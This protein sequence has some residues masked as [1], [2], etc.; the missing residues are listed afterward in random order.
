MRITIEKLYKQYKNTN[1]DVYDRCSNNRLLHL[2]PHKFHA[3]LI[4]KELE[5]LLASS[6]PFDPRPILR[7]LLDS[8]AFV[9]AFAFGNVDIT[10]LEKLV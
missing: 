6:E 2:I 8:T 3:S 7:K 1:I 9:R 10:S 5:N 4:E